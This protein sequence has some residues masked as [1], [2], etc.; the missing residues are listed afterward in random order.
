MFGQITSKI[1]EF[2]LESFCLPH[3]TWKVKFIGE[4]VDDCGGGFSE[5]IAEM[6]EELRNGSLPLLIPTPNCTEDSGD[7]SDYFILNPEACEKKHIPMFRFLGK[8][9]AVPLQTQKL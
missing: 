1:T 4:S 8:S 2:S 5:S 9:I 7:S 3:R 6:C